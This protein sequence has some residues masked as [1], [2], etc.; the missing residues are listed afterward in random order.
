M[1]KGTFIS[2]NP[3]GALMT[4][5]GSG[6]LTQIEEKSKVDFTK[7]ELNDLSTV[8]PPLILQDLNLAKEMAIELKGD[9][10]HLKIIDS[11]YKNL[12]SRRN[13][14][15]SVELLG[16]PISSAVAC[17]LAKTSGRTVFIQKQ[18]VSLDGFAL[19]VWYHIT[20]G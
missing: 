17:A 14:L 7:I 15:K 2:N 19:D 3:K 16:C 5:P 9:L 6:I 18:S 1:A 13:S 10:V 11:L 8:L 4:P 12:Y 20:E